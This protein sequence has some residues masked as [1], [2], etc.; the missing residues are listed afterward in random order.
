MNKKEDSAKNELR[1]NTES[2]YENQEFPFLYVEKMTQGQKKIIR[3]IDDLIRNKPFISCLKRLMQIQNKSQKRYG[4]GYNTLTKEQRTEFNNFHKEADAIIDEYEKLKKR[5]KKLLHNREYKIK[6]KIAWG[7]GL[8]S[9]LINLA[10]AR[11]KKDKYEVST[12]LMEGGD[13]CRVHADLGKEMWPFNRGEDFSKMDI[14]RQLE[15]IAYPI[16][17]GIHRKASKRDILDFIEKEWSIISISIKD[18]E[19][20]SYRARKRKHSQKMLDFIWENRSLPINKIKKNL[21]IEFPQNGI[22]YYEI[23]KL[24]QLEKQKRLKHLEI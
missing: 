13:M 24:I 1:E 23:N 14:K 19:E 17:I 8:D 20:K 9:Y 4:A 5:T 3:L 7:Y 6:Q 12:Y 2:N 10:I 11:Y 18:Y 16:S 15:L 21:D 22:V